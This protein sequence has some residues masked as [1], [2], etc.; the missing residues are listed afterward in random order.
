MALVRDQYW[1]YGHWQKPSEG[2]I[3]GYLSSLKTKYQ[4]E[5]DNDIRNCFSFGPSLQSLDIL[6]ES[7]KRKLWAIGSF[8]KPSEHKDSKFRYIVYAMV[9]QTGLPFMKDGRDSR[10]DYVKSKYEA[11]V[12]YNSGNWTLN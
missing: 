6:Q 3:Q 7:D 1:V 10:S 12:S 11:H 4:P 5:I 2:V 8:S 9:G